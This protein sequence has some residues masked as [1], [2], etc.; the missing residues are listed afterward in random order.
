MEKKLQ[1]AKADRLGYL[2]FCPTNLGTTMRASVHIKVPNL[3]KDMEKF[4]GLCAKL[5]LQP[6]GEKFVILLFVFVKH[7]NQRS[8]MNTY[9]S[10][11]QGYY[12]NFS[13]LCDKP[14]IKA[15]YL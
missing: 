4:N 12:Q 6:R 13:V 15:C 10:I 3:A 7:D 2:T 5:N 8:N 11:I 9:P 1:F 14:T